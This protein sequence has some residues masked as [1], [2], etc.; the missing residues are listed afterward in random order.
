M[1]CPMGCAS[2]PAAE[3]G[4]QSATRAHFCSARSTESRALLPCSYQRRATQPA[5]AKQLNALQELAMRA[6]C[7]K[8]DRARRKTQR[9]RLARRVVATF[10]LRRA[11]EVWHG[12]VDRI[13]AE[14]HGHLLLPPHLL[15]VRKVPLLHLRELVV[16]PLALELQ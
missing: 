1:D 12:G 2:D 5:P 3:A 10:S 13:D 8:S 4:R 6:E 11:G 7:E 15:H 9:L 16:E 14:F